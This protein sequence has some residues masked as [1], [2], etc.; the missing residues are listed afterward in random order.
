MDTSTL[1]TDQ[2]LPPYPYSPPSLLLPSQPATPKPLQQPGL[3]SQACSVQ[4]SGGQPPGRP[5]HFGTLYPPSSGGH[6]QQ[7]YHRPVSDFGL[8][9]VSIRVQKQGGGRGGG[10]GG[11]P[12]HRWWPVHAESADLRAG[13]H[14]PRVTALPAQG[15]CL[16]ASDPSSCCCPQP[17]LR[18][19]LADDRHS[20]AFSP[21]HAHAL[22]RQVRGPRQLP[23]VLCWRPSPCLCSDL[24]SRGRGALCWAN[25]TY[26]PGRQGL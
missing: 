22:S 1:P 26:L 15:F 3:T 4:P 23:P 10:A 14:A 6:G 19:V 11:A 20:D 12:P 5:L 9:S 13:L 8:G 16:P 21:G 25:G 2:R 18:S 24:C 17:A 7:S